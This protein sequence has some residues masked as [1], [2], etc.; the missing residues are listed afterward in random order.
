[1]RFSESA[2]HVHLL[3]YPREQ[4]EAA[5][6]SRF[7]ARVKQPASTFVKSTLAAD[8]PLWEKLTV[9]ERPGK[10]CFRFWQEGPGYD[11]NLTSPA[12][13]EASLDYIHNNPVKRGL[14]ERAVDWKWSSARWY[15]GEPPREQHPD[16]PR[17][18]GLPIGVLG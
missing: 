18:A 11:R 17:I 10:T 8:S 1:V 2:E 4:C 15:L 7:L 13:V 6:V 9:Q 16:L 12:A 3:V 5:A 14:C